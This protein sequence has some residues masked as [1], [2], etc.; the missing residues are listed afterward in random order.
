MK[1]DEYIPLL[2]TVLR[3]HVIECFGSPPADG[4]EEKMLKDDLEEIDNAHT[5]GQLFSV[6]SRQAFDIQ[7]AVGMAMRV[8]IEDTIDWEFEDVPIRGWD[9]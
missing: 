1:R 3:N 5:I 8:Y 9:T 6:M 4:E 7:G 2:K